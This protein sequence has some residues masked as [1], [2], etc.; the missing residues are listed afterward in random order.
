MR[1]L[2]LSLISFLLIIS[3]FA[4]APLKLPFQAVVRDSNG[5]LLKNQSVGVQISILKNGISGAMVFLE[6]HSALN[7]STNINGLLTLNIG[8]GNIVAGSLD[9]IDWANGD[10]FLKTEIDPT[11]GTNYSIQLSSPLLSVPYALHARNAEYVI[12]DNVYDGDSSSKNEIQVLELTTDS[13]LLKPSGKGVSLDDISKYV[14]ENQDRLERAAGD[15]F[16]ACDTVMS[17]QKWKHL[18]N[19]SKV[20]NT[21]ADTSAIDTFWIP[22]GKIVEVGI[23]SS[24]FSGVGTFNGGYSVLRTEFYVLDKDGN[25][26]NL[27]Y[28]DGEESQFTKS[29]GKLYTG[30][31]SQSSLYSCRFIT[32]QAGFY[33]LRGVVYAEH[34]TDNIPGTSY[35]AMSVDFIAIH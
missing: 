23:M 21:L 25:R 35:V 11:G 34:A 6:T 2:I 29:I 24:F 20:I 18:M 8:D 7:L 3:I 16:Y 1:R 28:H 5:E 27:I 19:G 14:L 22:K 26:V 9:K 15:T 33:Y 17:I 10:Y 32:N 30:N 13:I 12:N 4:Q 31:S